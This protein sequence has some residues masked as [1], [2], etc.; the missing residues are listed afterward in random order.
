MNPADARTT[1]DTNFFGATAMSQNERSHRFLQRFESIRHRMRRVNLGSML[2]WALLGGLAFLALLAWLDYRFEDGWSARALRLAG[3]GAA[4]VVLAA[5]QAWRIVR[6]WSRP[7]TAVE[8]EQRFPELGQRVRTTVQYAP[9]ADEAIRREGVTPS[10]VEALRHETAARAEPLGLDTVVPVRRLGLALGL[11]VLAVGTIV[12]GTISNWEWRTAVRRT[13]LSDEPYTQITVEPGNVLIDEGDHVDLKLTLNGRTDRDVAVYS[14]PAMRSDADW[15]VEELK[16][17]AAETVSARSVCYTSRLRRVMEPT[18]YRVVA[19]PSASDTFRIDVRYPLE[20][21]SIETEVTPPAYTGLPAK[22]NADGNVTALKGSRARLR[23]TLDRVPSSAEVQLTPI[24]TEPGE[25]PVPE[26]LPARING[27]TVTLDLDLDRDLKWSLLAKSADGTAL[28]DNAFRIRVREDQPPRVSFGE[29]ADELE[30]HTL[31]EVL[32]Q[33]R[34]S[35]DYGLARSGI[36]FQVNSE[37]EHVLLEEDFA[38]AAEAVSE[39]QETGRVTPRTRA[40][41]ERVLPLE[42]FSLTQKD[43]VAYFAFAEDNFPDEPHRTETDLRF[44]DIRPFKTIYRLVDMPPGMPN[45]RDNDLVALEELI[46]RQRYALNR[47]IRLSKF[48]SRW[49]DGELNTVERLIN[50]E[51][52]LANATHDLAEFFEGRG[53]DGADLLF[54][55]E[56]SMLAAVDSLGVSA[57]DTAVLQEKDAQQYLVEARDKLEQSINKNNNAAQRS[58]IRQFNRQL[59][60][61]LRRPRNDE[62]SERQIVERLQQLAMQEAEVAGEMMAMA[63]TGRGETQ[64]PEKPTEPMPGKGEPSEQ[65][66]D[67]TGASGSPATPGEKPEPGTEQPETPAADPNAKPGEGREPTDP[68]AKTGEGREP[69][70]P[71]TD[72]RPGKSD[73]PQGEPGES[74]AGMKDP[75]ELRQELEDRQADIVAEATELQRQMEGIDGITNLARE[76][77]KAAT[78]DADAAS[79]ALVRRDVEEAAEQ[80][81]DAAGQFRE[82]ARQVAGLLAGETARQ[83]A[84]TRDI[85]AE[86]AFRN[87][88]LADEL[89]QEQ[90][91]RNGARGS[92]NDEQEPR[93]RTGGRP[94]ERDPEDEADRL[95]AA[96]QTLQDLM[97]AIARSDKADSVE[98]KDRVAELMES[99]DVAEALERMQQLPAL[100][101][102]EG[103][104]A[105]TVVQVRDVSDRMEVTAVELDRLYRSIVM[106]RIEE[107]KDIER[108][109]VELQQQ[110]DLLQTESQV[111]GWHAEADALLDDLDEEDLGGGAADEL[112]DA[113]QEAG[114]G[115][116][117]VVARTWTVNSAGYFVAPARYR[118]SLRLLVDTL[119]QQIQELVLVDLLSARDEATPPGYEQFVDRYLK[120]LATDAGKEQP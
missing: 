97:Q 102:E 52:E 13:L 65:T 60:Q 68:D 36:V 62:E 86:I 103:P 26:T 70:D 111:A 87:E 17:G 109:V 83:V 93:E 20:I 61:K 116:G 59:A 33:V 101:A 66:R 81:G 74:G 21:E 47:T 49:G 48:P 115:T 11:V 18:E 120:V 1:E 14:R 28:P 96:G 84:M 117:G 9:Q 25:K 55:A 38:T 77:M 10:L 75:E 119:Q 4:L 37:E 114:A 39:A 31:A 40:A 106:P 110:L 72:A 67:A 46:R 51:T 79:G 42:Y 108:E 8:L 24:A 32:M 3:L 69:A 76:R 95:A 104:V 19:G 94:G 105:D 100:I 112:R 34:T 35:D 78:E 43:C 54:Q 41:L 29:P 53:T 12:A 5:Q 91:G 23:V 73:D 6:R 64:P 118:A 30:V 85:A 113:L 58:A 7:T 2:C 44:I 45:D 107:L 50:Y 92:R 15:S 27:K 63:R 71:Q 80:A 56:G 99:D 16:A 90:R 89:E 82:L 98:A 22:T 57:H 88:E